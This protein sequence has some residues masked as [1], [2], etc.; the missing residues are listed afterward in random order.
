MKVIFASIIMLLTSLSAWAYRPISDD[1][2][3]EII[4]SFNYTPNVQ[5]TRKAGSSCAGL[6]LEFTTTYPQRDTALLIKAKLFIP[7]QSVSEE[8]VLVAAQFPIVFILPPLGG[9]SR[10]DMMFGET[11]CKNRMAA[12]LITTNLTGLDQSTLV[13]VTDHDHTHRRVAS[14]IKAGIIVART[15]SVINT[16]KVG[17][18]GASLGGIL[19]SVA[20][21]VLPEVSAATFLVNGADVPH[22]LTNSDQGP[23]VKLKTERMREQGFTTSEQYEQYLNDNLEID[24]LHFVKLIQPDT[25]KLFL[26]QK[27]KS[28]PTQDQMLYYDALG[29][30]TDTKFYQIGHAETIFAVMGI[31]NG[32]QQIS[33]WFL[34]RFALP[35][36]RLTPNIY[37]I[38]SPRF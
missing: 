30:P 3:Q 26:S 27:D 36:P 16:E 33:D 21:S 38:L 20:F 34:T 35:N 5:I 12:L 4:E 1:K 25:I 19:G 17:L 29:K 11:V 28:V 18:F 2:L 22:I 31:G 32:K 14:A 15:Y 24:P 7:A 13:P 37:E 23:V 9:A 10:L 8:S 6:D